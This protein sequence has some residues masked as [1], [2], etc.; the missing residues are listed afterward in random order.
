MAASTSHDLWL[1][2]QHCMDLHVGTQDTHTRN[3][4]RADA[5]ACLDLWFEAVERE[6]RVACVAPAGTRQ[7]EF[8]PT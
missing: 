4:A 3:L 2:Y 1:C 8:G 5:R 7:R 6:L